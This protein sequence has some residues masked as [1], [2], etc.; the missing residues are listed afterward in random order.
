MVYWQGSK[1]NIALLKKAGAVYGLISRRG[2]GSKSDYLI[3]ILLNL[4]LRENGKRFFNL[5]G[6]RLKY[7]GIF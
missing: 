2:G 1:L 7:I 4:F 3:L 5:I 6:R